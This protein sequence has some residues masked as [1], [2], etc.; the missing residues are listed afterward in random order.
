MPPKFTPQQVPQKAKN[1][2][3]A[4]LHFASY[5]KR[6]LPIMAVAVLLAIGGTII[7]IITPDKL[8]EIIT[9]ISKDLF[10][11]SQGLKTEINVITRG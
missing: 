9:M 1:F 6:F 7:S 11:V 2:K 5:L 4:A 10:A 8:G 3:S